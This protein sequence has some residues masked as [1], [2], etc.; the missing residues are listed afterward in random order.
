MFFRSPFLR[1]VA[2]DFDYI[3]SR[4]M[5]RTERIMAREL[6]RALD[7]FAA[8]EEEAIQRHH[9]QQRHRQRLD[10][11]SH[12]AKPQESVKPQEIKNEAK[13]KPQENKA[14][15]VK[16]QE[17]ESKESKK[18]AGLQPQQQYQRR[19]DVFSAWNNSFDDFFFRDMSPFG[20][21]Y[22]SPFDDFH[23]RMNS[24]ERFADEMSQMRANINK[25]LENPEAPQEY[26]K[27]A[28]PENTSYFMRVET[29]D[30]GNVRVKTVQKNPGSEW[31]TKF[32]E[33]K[34][35]NNTAAIE[36]DPKQAVANKEQKLETSQK[37]EEKPVEIA[38]E[39][40]NKSS[41]SSAPS[42]SA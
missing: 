29:N 28:D 19:G 32:E 16:P 14:D 18:E 9:Q 23:S 13:T 36:K 30:N 39:S 42:A 37:K 40:Y 24:L 20:Y 41:E 10:R 7:S 15:S 34:I 33:Y 17:K 12:E 21:R 25:H 38:E 27:L 8:L 6:E 1:L 4:E 35:N 22:R 3:L 5:R 11:Q 26:P 2:H 31:V